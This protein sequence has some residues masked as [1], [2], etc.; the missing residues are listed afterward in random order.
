[1]LISPSIYFQ[2]LRKSTCTTKAS[3]ARTPEPVRSWSTFVE[4]VKSHQFDDI[5]KQFKSRDFC[6]YNQEG[7]ISRRGCERSFKCKYT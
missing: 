7:D 4:E 6:P 1:M 2:D 3:A 5:I